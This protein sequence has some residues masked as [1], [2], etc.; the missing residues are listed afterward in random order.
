VSIKSR[1]ECSPSD[2]AA[3]PF[4]DGLLI[5]SPKHQIASTSDSPQSRLRK[6]SKIIARAV[7]SAGMDSPPAKGLEDPISREPGAPRIT[8]QSGSLYSG[9]YGQVV[10]ALMAAGLSITPCPGTGTGEGEHSIALREV[11]SSNVSP[12]HPPWRPLCRSAQWQRC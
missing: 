8:T 6:L 7:T 5:H 4:G 11:Y 3:T 1:N 12:S 10:T 2:R 9:T